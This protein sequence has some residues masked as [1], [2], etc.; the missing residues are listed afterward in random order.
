[1][2]WRAGFAW[3]RLCS[4]LPLYD[5]RVGPA[6][7]G[8]ERLSLAP[9]PVAF[10]RRQRLYLLLEHA[11]LFLSLT[12]S[13]HWFARHVR[14]EG[15]WPPAPFVAVFFHYGT[16]LWSLRDL[17][18]EAGPAHFLSAPVD[19]AAARGRPLRRAYARLRLREVAR[20]GRAPV[21]HTGGSARRMAAILARGTDVVVVG[22]DV[23]PGATHGT[24]P[25]R[26]FERG[27]ALAQGLAQLAQAS[28]A[29]LV[30]FSEQLE[31]RERT[32]RIDPPLDVHEVA[33]AVQEL[34]ARL[35]ARVRA[36][37]AAWHFWPQ[38]SDYFSDVPEARATIEG[39]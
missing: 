10:R 12:R 31:G 1:V 34:A 13:R 30:V 11:D 26:L 27:A 32:L 37:P 7:A 17:A 3:L 22:G 8:A 9:D 23:P 19:Y 25:V 5:E 24:G 21:L 20:A 33:G 36:D 39:A 2:P 38:L 16:G 15:R 18:G 14:T 29:P 6:L 35:E 4:R 28:G